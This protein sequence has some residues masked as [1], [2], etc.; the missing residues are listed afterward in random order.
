MT[1]DVDISDYDLDEVFAY[2]VNLRDSGVTNMF[3]SPAYVQ[4][5]FE[6]SRDQSFKLVELWMNSFKEE[7][8]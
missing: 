4:T 8:E 2:L 7:T 3:G 5:E 1:T 6:C